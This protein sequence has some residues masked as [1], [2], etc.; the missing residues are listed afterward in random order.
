MDDD[1]PQY[2]LLLLYEDDT[3]RVVCHWHRK[4]TEDEI[5]DMKRSLSADELVGAR[6]ILISETLT[7]FTRSV[8]K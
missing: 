5:A 3:M 6:A 2:T 4:P 7:Y 8:T 1:I